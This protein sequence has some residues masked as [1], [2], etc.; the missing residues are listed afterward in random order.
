MVA[1]IGVSDPGTIAP[2]PSELQSSLPIVA[3][4][5]VVSF[6]TSFLLF[7]RLAWQLVRSRREHDAKVNQFV[8]LIFNL[9]IADISQAAA[10]LINA[11]W[12][13]QDAITVG[14]SACW[15]QGWFISTGDLASG[16]FTFAIALHAFA[17]IVWNFRLSHKPF[18][19]T[20]AGLWVFVYLCA[21]LGVRPERS[22]FS[23]STKREIN[24][25][26]IISDTLSGQ[27]ASE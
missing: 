11:H 6:V 23:P 12:L 22:F 20:I 3:A 19:M 10:F 7:L 4:L 18:V 25:K 1:N 8:L 15:A 26:G 2:L 21:I 14:T 27:L 13:R 5:G 9:I 17:D 24:S 16:A